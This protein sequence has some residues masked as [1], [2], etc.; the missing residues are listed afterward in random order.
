MAKG[1]LSLV[2]LEIQGFEDVQNQVDYLLELLQQL[3]RRAKQVGIVLGKA[4]H[5]GKSVQFARLFVAVDRAKFSQTQ[6]QVPVGTR[7]GLEYFA[8]V[9]AVHGLQQVLF[10]LFR[11]ADGLEGVLAV[12]LVVAGA[13]VQ[14]FVS[15]VRGDDGQ[16]PGFFLGPLQELLQPLAQGRSFGEPQR[17]A[18]AHALGEGEQLQF[19]AQFAVVPF[20]GFFQQMQVL[21]QH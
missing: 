16:V 13:H 15:N 17:Q 21:L 7:L 4:A 11:C 19:L 5:A 20:L 1:N 12:L 10:T 6:G 18:L 9:R 2:V 14:F 8:V 3:I